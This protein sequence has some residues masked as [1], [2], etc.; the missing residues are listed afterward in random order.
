VGAAATR[1]GGAVPPGRAWHG[2]RERRHLTRP[3]S[4]LWRRPMRDGR[5]G[6]HPL[7]Q[8]G[9]VAACLDALHPE[10]SGR[11][12]LVHVGRE[13]L[14]PRTQM[15]YLGTRR[16]GRGGEGALCAG[17]GTKQADGERPTALLLERTAPIPNQLPEPMIASP[18]AT[19]PTCR[20]Q[21][22]CWPWLRT[23][24][25]AGASL[26]HQRTPAGRPETSERRCAW[27]TGWPDS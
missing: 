3:T 20:M 22:C 2:H 24:F 6:R 8:L 23:R 16:R 21:E 9:Q 18:S 25:G 14:D 5:V 13:P 26:L 7:Q 17:I 10:A 11:K 27:T 4:W 12:S 15:V 1:V 19:R